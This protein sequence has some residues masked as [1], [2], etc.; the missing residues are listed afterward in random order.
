MLLSLREMI[1]VGHALRK[2]SQKRDV[3]EKSFAVIN[4]RG[5]SVKL[6]FDI[7]HA[8]VEGTYNKK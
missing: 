6:Y 7:Y 4:L 1:H 5:V 8:N 2:Y 3:S